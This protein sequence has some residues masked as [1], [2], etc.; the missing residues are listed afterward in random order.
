MKRVGRE[1]S[2]HRTNVGAQAFG[3][4]TQEGVRTIRPFD[5]IASPIL[6]VF[7]GKEQEAK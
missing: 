2:I 1:V 5:L 7:R 4:A 3:S 6:E